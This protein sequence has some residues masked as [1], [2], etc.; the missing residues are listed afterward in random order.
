MNKFLLFQIQLRSGESHNL[1]PHEDHSNFFPHFCLE[2]VFPALAKVASKNPKISLWTGKNL[3]VQPETN[4]QKLPILNLWM[5]WEK[6]CTNLS[7]TIENKIG[8]LH[9]TRL[10]KL[11]IMKEII[12]YLRYK[13]LSENWQKSVINLEKINFEHILSVQQN[14]DVRKDPKYLYELFEIK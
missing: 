10:F 6:L 14:F 9:K 11:N 4:S 12:H 7:F 1:T 13:S 3:E 2:T 8:T 5:N